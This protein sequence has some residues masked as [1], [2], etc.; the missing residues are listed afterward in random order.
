MKAKIKTTTT[1]LD[2]RVPTE[3]NDEHNTAEHERE[4]KTTSDVWEA[5]QKAEQALVDLACLY[6][7]SEGTAL[8]VDRAEEAA[9]AVRRVSS[10][11]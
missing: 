5:L 9:R 4:I 8:L 6:Q 1:P 2:Y 3:E 10:E 7:F 11:L